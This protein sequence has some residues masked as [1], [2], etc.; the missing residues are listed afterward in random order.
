MSKVSRGAIF[1]QSVRNSVPRTRFDLSFTNKFSIKPGYLTPVF[2]KRVVPGDV[3]SFNDSVLLRTQPL[4]TPAFIDLDVDIR[5]FYIP[6]RLIWKNF[7]DFIT[8]PDSGIVHPYLKY[9]SSDPLCANGS[10]YDYLGY[11]SSS[12]TNVPAFARS[13]SPLRL[14]AYNLI[15]NTWYRDENLQNEIT[16]NDSDGGL[17]EAMNLYNLMLTSWKRDYF[18]SCLPD[19]QFGNAAQ[20]ALDVFLDSNLNSQRVFIDVPG[21]GWIHANASYDLGADNGGY[22]N[23]TDSTWP[24]G[25]SRQWALDPGDSL[26][27]EMSVMQLREM[28]AVQKF[29]ELLMTAGR[30]IKE[31]TRA[32][33][34]VDVP[35]DR[36]QYPE[37]LGGGSV[38]VVIGEVP[39]TSSTDSVSPQATLA[40]RGISSNV[41][42]VPA[43]FVPEYGWIIGVCVVRPR[44]DYFQGLDRELTQMD[45][46]D[47][48]NPMFEHIGEQ[49]VLKSELFGLDAANDGL[50]GYQSRNADYKYYNNEIHGEMRNMSGVSLGNWHIAR[51]FTNTPSLN[52]SFLE[53]VPDLSRVFAVDPS[54]FDPFVVELRHGISSIRPM[55]EFSTPSLIG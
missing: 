29:R 10:V 36:A 46:Y 26:K 43:K 33:F 15:W 52:S 42:N 39:Q 23:A 1:N 14:R 4:V 30:R 53:C 41:I 34:G 47:Y 55:S 5:Y 21:S 22:P 11:V 48:Y 8:N 28:T 16:V 18:T 12:N 35:D 38:P 49:E 3:F 20:A 24:S 17:N 50:F 9:D 37:F 51:N 2:C 32:Q 40:G 6:N 54:C 25:N 27:A 19:A 13:L 45:Y 44:A 31:F 7:N